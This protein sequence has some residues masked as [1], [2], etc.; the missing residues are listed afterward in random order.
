[1]AKKTGEK[2]KQESFPKL[3]IRKGTRFMR[4]E[5]LV[6]RSFDNL[7]IREKKRMGREV[8]GRESTADRRTKTRK[9]KIA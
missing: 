6:T 9:G 4:G 7:K 1:M 2:N 8:V 5:K 3:C